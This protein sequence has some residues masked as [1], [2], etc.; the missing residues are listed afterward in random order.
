MAIHEAGHCLARDHYGLPWCGVIQRRPGPVGLENRS[1]EGHTYLKELPRWGK[2]GTPFQSA[3]D[4]WAGSIAEYLFDNPNAEFAK[5]NEEVADEGYL[6]SSYVSATDAERIEG[7]PDRQRPLEKAWGIVTKNSI[8][9][10][11]MA[12]ELRR[13]LRIDSWCWDGRDEN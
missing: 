1:W 11:K 10:L 7:Y 13:T 3:V 4:A 12:K 8:E 2:H 9:L 5:F 6:F